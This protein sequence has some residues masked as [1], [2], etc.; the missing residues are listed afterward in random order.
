V[1]GFAA[2]DLLPIERAQG[3]LSRGNASGGLACLV[4]ILGQVDYLPIA[5]SCSASFPRVLA[6][7]PHF[8]H[9][10]S[11]IFLEKRGDCS[12]PDASR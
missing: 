6:A 10:R 5:V 11:S 9:Y 8:D 1:I 7:P 3:P 4:L 2:A 12:R